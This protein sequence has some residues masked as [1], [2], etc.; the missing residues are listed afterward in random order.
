VTVG[1]LTALA[2]ELG[3]LGTGGSDYHGDTETYAEAHARL[4]V[5]PE[6]EPRLREA[7]ANAR[8][9]YASTIV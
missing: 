6:V 5:P 1:R 9:R 2:A 7:M 8:E 4:W 3:L